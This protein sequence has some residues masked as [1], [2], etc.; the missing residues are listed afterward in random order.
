MRHPAI[1][2][3]GRGAVISGRKTVVRGSVRA[4][5]NGLPV[6]VTVNGH[7][8]TLTAKSA[9]RATYKAVFDEPLGK[10]RI[11]AVAKDAGGNTRSASI[12]VRNK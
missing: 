7:P 6:T 12:T 2:S 5:V 11:T 10:H 8:A 1:G 3:P 4:G 9:T